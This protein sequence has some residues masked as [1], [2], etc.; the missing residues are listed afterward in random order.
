MFLRQCL[1]QLVQQGHFF[2]VVKFRFLTIDSAATSAMKVDYGA[3][4][5][6]HSGQNGIFAAVEWSNQ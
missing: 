4:K 2:P 5:F 1:S 6:D 3:V